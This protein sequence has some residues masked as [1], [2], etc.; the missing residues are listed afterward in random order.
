MDR[1]K[2]KEV[3]NTCFKLWYTGKKQSRNDVD[4]LMNKSL[5]NK[6]V[7]VRRQEHRIIMIKLIIEDLILNVINI[8]VP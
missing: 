1:K 2:V 5:K 4:I 7:T 6:V 3:E 8:Y